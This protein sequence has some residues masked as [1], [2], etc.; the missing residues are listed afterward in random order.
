MK[1][2]IVGIRRPE[3]RSRPAAGRG[4]PSVWFPSMATMLSEDNL[5]LLRLIHAKRPKSLTALADLTGR[6]VPNLS[7]SLRMMEGYGL[8][9]LKRDGNAVEPV[10]L[11]TEFLV[12]L[13]DPAR[14]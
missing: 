1:R 11:A 6:Q 4:Q 14:T 5:A 10:A 2:C 7:R 13:N 12:V 3:D 9:K 8:V